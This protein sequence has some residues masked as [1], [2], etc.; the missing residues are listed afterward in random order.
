MPPPIKR[1][2]LWPYNAP[3]RLWVVLGCR[4]PRPVSIKLSKRECL[5]NFYPKD[6]KTNLRGHF[7][8]EKEKRTTKQKIFEQN[9]A[10]QVFLVTYSAHFV[11]SRLLGGRYIIYIWAFLGTHRVQFFLVF[12]KAIKV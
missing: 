2:C 12:F 9:D 5:A 3:D 11:I 8:E 1:G 6:A 10:F 7:V 4:V